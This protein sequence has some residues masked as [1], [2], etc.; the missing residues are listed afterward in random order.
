MLTT[1]RKNVSA[2]IGSAVALAAI[3]GATWLLAKKKPARKGT[4]WLM[5]LSPADFLS[6]SPMDLLKHDPILSRSP[7]KLLNSGP[8]KLMREI[9]VFPRLP[10]LGLPGLR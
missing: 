5:S 10:R 7:K 4:P 8:F 6:V 1:L 9:F 2:Q 3:A